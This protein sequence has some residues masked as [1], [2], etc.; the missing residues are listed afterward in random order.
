MGPLA[1][2]EQQREFVKAFKE[3]PFEYQVFVARPIN[4]SYLRVAMK[5]EQMSAEALRTIAE[6]LLEIT[7]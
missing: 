3:L 4:Q 5:L 6:G 2:W 1:K 7:Y